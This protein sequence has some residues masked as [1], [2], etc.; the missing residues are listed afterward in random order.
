MNLL[1]FYNS[2]LD[3]ISY[4]NMKLF[5]GKFCGC[6]QT[7]SSPCLRADTKLSALI[8]SFLFGH[9]HKVFRLY[10]FIFIVADTKLPALI[11]SFLFVCMH[12]VFRLYKVI[13]FPRKPYPQHL[14]F[15]FRTSPVEL[16]VRSVQSW[17]F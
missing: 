3:R 16:P 2:N 6:T 13:I 7:P 17:Y 15:L 11:N 12:E 1:Y 5:G 14:Y 9:G 10:K 8:N 4:Q